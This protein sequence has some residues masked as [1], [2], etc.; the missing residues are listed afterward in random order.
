MKEKEIIKLNFKTYTALFWVSLLV[1]IAACFWIFEKAAIIIIIVFIF[2]LFFCAPQVLDRLSER[3]GYGN[4]GFSNAEFYSNLK[5]LKIDTISI[6]LANIQKISVEIDGIPPYD[7]FAD[8]NDFLRSMMIYSTVYISLKNG[9]TIDF[10]VTYLFGL[11]KFVD[12][13][14]MYN[15]PVE[16]PDNYKKMVLDRVRIKYFYIALFL[17]LAGAILSIFL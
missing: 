6:P 5:I 8:R 16:L 15:I 4:S 11:K 10:P 14:K 17:V 9:E 3:F 12:L 2:V 7:Y 1:I 13:S